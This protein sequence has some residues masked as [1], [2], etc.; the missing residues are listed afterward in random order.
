MSHHQGFD[1]SV[2]VGDTGGVYPGTFVSEV[3]DTNHVLVGSVVHDQPVRVPVLPENADA[4]GVVL[5]TG[6]GVSALV[7]VQDFL[8][9][10]QLLVGAGFGELRSV[11]QRLRAAQYVLTHDRGRRRKASLRRSRSSSRGVV[12][13]VASRAPSLSQV[14][15]PSWGVVPVSGVPASVLGSVDADRFPKDSSGSI[16]G[17]TGGAGVSGDDYYTRFLGSL[18]SESVVSMS[19]KPSLLGSTRPLGVGLPVVSDDVSVSYLSSNV[20]SNI[21]ALVFPSTM[22]GVTPRVLGLGDDVRFWV[23]RVFRSNLLRVLVENMGAAQARTKVVSSLA[24]NGVV[25]GARRVPVAVPVGSPVVGDYVPLVDATSA[26]CDAQ[27]GVGGDNEGGGVVS[28]GSSKVAGVHEP[29]VLVPPEDGFRVMT[30][31]MVNSYLEKTGDNGVV[32]GGFGVGGLLYIGG[33]NMNT[34]SGEEPLGKHK[35]TRGK[36]KKSASAVS[37]GG[38]SRVD[39]KAAE[40]RVEFDKRRATRAQSR[41]ES[42][43]VGEHG[44]G[45]L[46]DRSL[47]PMVSHAFTPNTSFHGGFSWGVTPGMVWSHGGAADYGVV[48]WG[49]GKPMEEEGVLG[50]G[51]PVVENTN[52]SG[53]RFDYDGRLSRLSGVEMSNYRAFEENTFMVAA[54]SGSRLVEPAWVPESVK[55]YEARLSRLE[56]AVLGEERYVRGG[57]SRVNYKWVDTLSFLAMFG[58]VRTRHLGQLFGEKY[59]AAYSRLTRMESFG[60]VKRARV[61]GQLVWMLTQAGIEVSGF[62]VRELFERDI[63]VMMIAH[64][65]VL[66]HVASALWGASVNVLMDEEYPRMN[67]R[68]G[69][70]LVVP[71]D[72]MVPDR[73]INSSL[74]VMRRGMR[75]EEFVPVIRESIDV[76]FARWEEAGGASVNPVSPEQYRGNEFMWALFPPEGVGRAYHVPDLV[77]SR[78]RD[79]DG[80]PNS[81]AVEV[82]LSV[83]APEALEQTLRSY[84]VDAVLFGEVVWVVRHG[85][86]AKRIMEFVE[87]HRGEGADRIRVVPLVDGEGQVLPVGVNVWEV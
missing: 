80:A 83:K 34:R 44:F 87:E 38:V 25:D 11:S 84:M 81:V 28:G 85:S 15:V 40:S 65:T 79:A 62:D 53:F 23:A 8:P 73:V 61:P 32:D 50:S 47:V 24:S 42:D 31:G 63:N 57:P 77:L 82:E 70:G 71:G 41:V 1:V 39:K 27:H 55:E 66:H 75:R 56:D 78:P 69:T 76:A 22:V 7:G 12:D 45:V 21:D 74:G 13:V 29:V 4:T 64:N 59:Q 72:Y 86:V 46:S 9:A 54:K 20:D 60:L 3:D 36:G 2:F 18:V 16:V 14:Y 58:W 30:S 43:L 67:R 26:G 10:E 19:A 51:V 48:Q 33:L 6:D 37:G 68:A 5:P 17:V 49:Y 35:N 52:G